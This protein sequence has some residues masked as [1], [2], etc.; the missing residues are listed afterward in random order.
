MFPTNLLARL[1]QLNRNTPDEGLATIAHQAKVLFK[2]V[3][4]F[5]V[6][7][8]AIGTINLVDDMGNPAALPSGFLVTRSFLE[9]VTAPTSAGAATV[10][11]T[12]GE[13]AA[14]ILAAT[15]K[16]SVTGNL[17]GV[18]DGV[19]AN[20][21]QMTA[22]RVPSIVVAVAALTAG[23]INVYVEGVYGK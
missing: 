23:K 14:D 2:F 18:S 12:T 13:T 7:G 19:A 4:D 5:P 16:A 1:A 15:A 8:G 9:V 20:F 17:D 22:A 3:Y 10:A 21:K 6:S 11:A